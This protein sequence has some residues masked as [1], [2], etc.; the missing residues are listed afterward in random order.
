MSDYFLP[1]SKPSISRE[2]I[3]EVVSS[4]ESG[5]ITTGPK[6]K[7]FEEALQNYLQAPFVSVLNSATSGLHLVLKIFGLKP[8]DEVITTPIT[9][10]ATLNTIVHCGAKP[11]L[12]DV[13]LD[14]YNIDAS[15][16]KKAITAKTKVI[17]PVHY[18]GI[19]VDL[20]PIYELAEHYGLR[21]LEDA[22]HAIGSFYKGKIIG[23]FGDT[24]VFSFHPNKVM[25][26]GEGGCITTSDEK[27]AK[28]IN[29]MRF[30]GIDRE[31]WNRNAKEGSQHYDVIQ[32]GFKY[33]MMDIQAALGLHQ[34][35]ELNNFIQ[36]RTHLAERYQQILQNWPEW[37][38]PKMPDY[39]IRNSWYIYA[40]L[41]NPEQA[42][43]SRDEFMQKM[44]EYNIG[45]G[46]HYQA[47]HLFS[48]YQ[49]EFGFRRGQ[50]PNAESISDRIVSL[51][52]FPDMSENDQDRV[53]GAMKKIFN[54]E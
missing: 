49:Q 15:Q 29:I 5:W 17:M 26:T 9:F 51:P 53:I 31:A 30:H 20:D 27:L 10:V 38:L 4:L 48:F 34:L 11:V 2:A 25:T 39:D 22:A 16:I 37:T 32:P 24:Q 23:S 18:A 45:T 54:H 14:T 52:L 33:N 47:A 21:V 6:V 19:P 46:Y 44:K 1:F 36:K 50:F 42:G 41:I 12:V 13:D 28:Q 40:P 35:P 7:L 43:I 3:N 8:G